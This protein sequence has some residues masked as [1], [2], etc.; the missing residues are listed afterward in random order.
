VEK[1]PLSFIMQPDPISTLRSKQANW[2]AQRQAALEREGA[3]QELGF[4]EAAQINNMMSSQGIPS[5]S[6]SSAA[7]TATTSWSSN[8]RPEAV[9]DKLTERIADRLRSEL[10]VEM[11]KES[12]TL[13]RKLV[14]EGQAM[15]S[16]LSQELETQNT[17]PVCYE[18]MVPPM[19]AP[20]ILFPCGHTF[21]AKCL[22]TH[23]Q[24]HNKQNCPVCRK[25]IDSKAPNYSLQQLILN[26]ASKKKTIVQERPMN[27]EHQPLTTS[28]LEEDVGSQTVESLRRQSDRIQVRLR[29]LQNE[30]VDTIHEQKT[31]EERAAAARLVYS[32]MYGEEQQVLEKMKALQAELDLLRDQLSR[33]KEKLAKAEE[34]AGAVLSRREL[35][36]Q[37]I[38]P[39]LLECEKIR[40]LE[41]GLREERSY[42]N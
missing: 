29:V 10:K 5:S 42:R 6:S 14:Q 17:C 20:L 7:A 4:S 16:Y 32:H 26:F 15:D 11:Q 25:K 30:L 34:E 2:L 22:D 27:P 12:Q 38:E 9:I 3:M 13:Q 8:L 37:T 31:Y 28:S 41:T 24:T 33:Q 35:L 39:L 40:I 36:S 23:M 1:R 21:C 19:H 18:L